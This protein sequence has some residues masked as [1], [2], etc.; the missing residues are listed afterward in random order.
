MMQNGNEKGRKLAILVQN[1]WRKI[2]IDLQLDV[3]DATAFADRARKKDYDALLWSF[4]NNPK[5]D[6]P[7][8]WQSDG[9]YNWFGYNNPQV[10]TL[11]QRGVSSI[12]PKDAQQAFQEA[13][14]IIHADQ[15]V[16]FYYGSMV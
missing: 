16:T 8:I 5:V 10:D 7:I 2:G 11:L 9:R 3:L 15:P 12:H 1:Q 4:G 14:R 13:Q 6:L